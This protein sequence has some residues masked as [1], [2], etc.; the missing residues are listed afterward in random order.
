ML[1]GSCMRMSTQLFFIKLYFVGVFNTI[2]HVRDVVTRG[3]D[4]YKSCANSMCVWPQFLVLN[5]VCV[6][7]SHSTILFQK[8]NP[9]PLNL[10]TYNKKTRFI[11]CFMNHDYVSNFVGKRKSMQ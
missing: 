7:M 4:S 9:E 2:P 3:N 5:N 10:T 11:A 1:Q 8:H 6:C